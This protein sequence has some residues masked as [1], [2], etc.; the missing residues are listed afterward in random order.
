MNEFNK[1][2]T[3]SEYETVA[4]HYMEQLGFRTAARNFNCRQGEIDLI[5]Y[6]EGYLVF[7]EVKYRAS[8]AKGM[9][10]DAVNR[11]KQIR[12]CRSAD[13]YRLLHGYPDDSPVRYDVIAI[14]G[15]DNSRITWYKNAFPHIYAGRTSF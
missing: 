14:C 10:E 13:Y 15:K 3:G 4:C 12:I 2:K 7:G 1:R 6:H 11:A 9:P 8:D 5:G